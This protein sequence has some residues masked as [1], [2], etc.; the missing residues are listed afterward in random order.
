[1]KLPI[2][3]TT[4]M[5]ADANSYSPSAGKPVQ[6]MDSWADLGLPLDIV[7]PAPVSVDQ[8]SLAH[9]R[10][11]VEGVLSG[12]IN[13]G[14]GNKLASVA[15][16]LPYT[17]GVMLS[18]ARAALTKSMGRDCPLFGFPSCRL[19]ALPAAIAPSTA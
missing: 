3:Y 7:A 15:A 11:F 4:K 13:N 6:V 10:A 9:D 17:S 1:M 5:V 12:K 2:H 19:R 8:F 18:A 16:S 14:F